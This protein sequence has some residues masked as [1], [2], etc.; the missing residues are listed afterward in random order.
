M[1][2]EE[3]HLHQK[4]SQPTKNPHHADTET[5]SVIGLHLAHG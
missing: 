3:R 2:W 4:D 5:S 1:R